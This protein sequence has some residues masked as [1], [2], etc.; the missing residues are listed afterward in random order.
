MLTLKVPFPGMGNVAR[1]E[2]PIIITSGIDKPTRREH[3]GE[4][5]VESQTLDLPPYVSS[6]DRPT[7]R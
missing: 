4:G 5:Q 7:E 2:V 1:L 6:L 3:L